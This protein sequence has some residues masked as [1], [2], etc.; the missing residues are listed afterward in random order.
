MT[1]TVDVVQNLLDNLP[2]NLKEN[3]LVYRGYQT[4]LE[5]MYELNPYI[6][7]TSMI[8]S[9]PNSVLNEQFSITYLENVVDGFNN[10]LNNINLRRKLQ[11]LA[12]I[13]NNTMYSGLKQPYEVL[14]NEY[15]IASKDFKSSKGKSSGLKYAYNIYNQMNLGTGISNSLDSLTVQDLNAPLSY[16]SYGSMMTEVFNTTVKLIAHPIGIGQEYQRKLIEILADQFGS[17]VTYP[18]IIFQLNEISITNPTGYITIYDYS[19]INNPIPY[20]IGV[21]YDTGV[22]FLKVTLSD[23]SY[24]ERTSGTYLGSSQSNSNYTYIGSNI[25]QYSRDLVYFYPTSGPVLVYDPNL[26]YLLIQN[27]T[28]M[29]I[30]STLGDGLYSE[31][32]LFDM[33]F[34]ILDEDNIGN[35]TIES[36]KASLDWNLTLNQRNDSLNTLIPQDSLFKT[37]NQY[38]IQNILKTGLAS[39]ISQADFDISTIY[40][41]NIKIGDVIFNPVIDNPIIKIGESFLRTYDITDPSKK[42]IITYD[43]NKNYNSY[44]SPLVIDGSAMIMDSNGQYNWSQIPI[45]YRPYLIGETVIKVTANSESCDFVNGLILT[46]NSDGVV[47]S[48]LQGIQEEFSIISKN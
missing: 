3:P 16:Y 44:S 28:I 10:A 11:N 35:N 31:P 4:F 41:T 23:G 45:G 2:D 12:V 36:L 22:G 39:Q 20:V 1:I 13:L 34:S 19:S 37:F 43:P 9:N 26:Y 27:Y 14:N 29:D 15:L 40:N 33:F 8:Y 46:E 48:I 18:Q 32:D 30:K 42:D 21:Q 6:F 47:T 17:Q 5:A 25:Q 7:D 38:K 24:Y